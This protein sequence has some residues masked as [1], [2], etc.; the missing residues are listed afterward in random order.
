[1]CVLTWS[2]IDHGRPEP[3]F[4]LLHFGFARNG[5]LAE[6]LLDQQ[7]DGK[8][9]LARDAA[10][11]RLAVAVNTREARDEQPAKHLAPLR[12]I[13]PEACVGERSFRFLLDR[14]CYPPV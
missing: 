13:R 11:R 8:I 7:I 6:P 3:G 1:M 14:R 4:Q 12:P 5:Q 9:A 10:P 2:N